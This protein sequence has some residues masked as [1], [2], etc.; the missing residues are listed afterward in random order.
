[1]WCCEFTTFTVIEIFNNKERFDRTPSFYFFW[2]EKSIFLDTY[3]T[4]KP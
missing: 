2:K 4:M 1:M 3:H